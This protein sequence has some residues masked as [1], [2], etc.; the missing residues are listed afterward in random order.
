MSY[1]T[2]SQNNDDT[3]LIWP[4]FVDVLAS[5]LMVIIF[6]VLLFT[7]SQ[8]YLGDLVV[9]KNEQIQNLEKTIEIQDETI[10]EQDSTLTDKEITLIERQELINQLDNELV[11]LDEE[12]K[13]KQSE[14]ADKQNLLTSKDQEIS[15]QEAIIDQKED[16]IITLDTLIEEQALDIGKLNQMI[17]QLTQELS[18]SLEEKEVL[19]GELNQLNQ[20]QENLKNTL[21][22][23]GGKNEE[24]VGKLSD[25]QTRIQSL[26]ETLSSSEI[27][28]KG[29][30]GKIAE[31]KDQNLSLQGQIED[32]EGESSIKSENLNDALIKISRLS[33]DIKILSKEIQ[34]LNN[35]LDSKEAEIANNKIELGELGDR[36]NR[37]LT[38]E[39]FKLQKYKSD[40]FGKLSE[41]LGE[42]DDIQIKGD[43]FIFQ[44]EILFESGS[45]EIQSSGRVALSLIAKTISDLIDEIPTELNWVLQIDG[46][47]DKVPI[48][49]SK[50]PSNWELSHARA[51]EVVKFFIGQGVPADRLSANGYGEYQPINLGD[52]REDLKQNRRIELKITQK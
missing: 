13:L 11:I 10:V 17:A 50:F 2:K 35:L 49:T 25:S 39:L 45:I 6:I 44:S 34:V 33:E 27:E 16:T 46:H 48:S 7:V 4:G 37:V 36:L 3:S 9:G 26:L 14:I 12:I 5:T 41:A 51:L 20:E 40:F 38:S 31:I 43:R 15:L 29:L 52:T 22:K 24:L 47:T 32:L 19:R 8:V 18:L 42:R 1:H 23:L 30:Q 28:N 21:T